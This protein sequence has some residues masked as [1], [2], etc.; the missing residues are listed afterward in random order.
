MQSNEMEIENSNG[1]YENHRHR[2]CS[3]IYD[4]WIWL[5]NIL[6]FKKENFASYFEFDFF[7]DDDRHLDF[8]PSSSSLDASSS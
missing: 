5:K 1:T 3:W 8:Q 4:D 7:F 6:K 2:I